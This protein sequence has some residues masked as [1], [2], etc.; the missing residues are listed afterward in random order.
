MNSIR[1]KQCELLNFSDSALCKR[2]G[3]PLRT[4]K[5]KRKRRPFSFITVLAIAAL[6]AVI[7]Y[8]YGGLQRS[9]ADK[10]TPGTDR[11]ATETRANS[12]RSSRS[13]YDRQ[14]AARF[15]EAVKNSNSL[16]ESRN[17]NDE[18]QRAIRQS[19]GQQ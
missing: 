10:E 8:A 5:K 14:R 13:E 9:M 1:C 12:N 18:L 3:N 11:R 6:A 19:Q 16:G 17:H 2:C 4:P 15:G 7:Y